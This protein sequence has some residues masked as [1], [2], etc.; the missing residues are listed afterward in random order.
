MIREDYHTIDSTQKVHLSYYTLP[1]VAG[2]EHANFPVSP[3]QLLPLVLSE[4][5]VPSQADWSC[6]PLAPQAGLRAYPS[7]LAEFVLKAA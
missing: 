5:A 6:I 3:G 1:R 7:A 4:A 2:Q